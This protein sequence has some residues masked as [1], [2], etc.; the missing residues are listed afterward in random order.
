[1]DNFRKELHTAAKAHVKTVLLVCL[2]K[3][4]DQNLLFT[5]G[6]FLEPV[7]KCLYSTIVVDSLYNFERIF[8]EVFLVVVFSVSNQSSESN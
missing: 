8:W 7:I 3:I 6:Q 2:T 5:F 1:M 4:K